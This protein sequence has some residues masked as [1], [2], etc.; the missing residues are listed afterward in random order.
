MLWFLNHARFAR[1][2]ILIGLAGLTMANKECEKKAEPRMLK[3]NIKVVQVEASTFLDSSQFNFSEQSRERLSAA[4]FSSSYFYERNYYP[5]V[6]EYRPEMQIESA[7]TSSLLS[8]LSAAG[9]SSRP[10]S[11]SANS[12]KLQKL[13]VAPVQTLSDWFPNLKTNSTRLGGVNGSGSSRKSELNVPFNS[14]ASCLIERPQ[15]YVFAKALS[16][17]AH[18]GGSLVFG[19]DQSVAQ[20]PLQASF[21][22]DRMKFDLGMNIFDSWTQEK[23][24]SQI[25]SVK[26]KDM[27]LK[28][29]LDLGLFHIGPQIYRKT[30]LAEVV[31]E[32]V[33]KVV[34]QVGEAMK[35][36]SSQQWKSRVVISSDNYVGILG[37]EELGIK[38][39]DQF[40]IENEN[41]TWLGE[42]CGPSSV[43]VGSIAVTQ[44]PWIVE[45]DRIGTGLVRAKVLNENDFESI[46]V[47]AL[48]RIHK[49]LPEVNTNAASNYIANP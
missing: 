25:A 27:S 36:M 30:G 3:K 20:L 33:K 34:D 1:G 2:V 49:L 48:V 19:F 13:E 47:G 9:S 16:L 10:Q 23:V 15:H 26:K 37:G 38:I 32:A 43:L 44:T 40:K 17:E 14:E 45:V 24:Q 8:G 29:G 39:G 6:D 5:K 12:S 46:K 4:L 7:A 41:H 28:V 31:D 42:P 18:S 22:L 35:I 11:R 21:S